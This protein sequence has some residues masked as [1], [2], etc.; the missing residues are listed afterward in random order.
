MIR[1]YFFLLLA[2]GVWT[3]FS[4]CASTGGED[5]QFAFVIAEETPLNEQGPMQQIPAEVLLE[6]GDRVRL[7]SAAGNHF[8]V[9][10]REGRRGFV[11]RAV[12]RGQNPEE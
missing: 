10:T 7:I 3:L 8:Y 9:E 4:G 2:L 11:P 1:N 6:P 5:D 12:V